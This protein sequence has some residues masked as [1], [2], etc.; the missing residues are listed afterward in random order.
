MTFVSTN[1]DHTYVYVLESCKP[2]HAKPAFHWGAN[3][4]YRMN[5]SGAAEKA[6]ELSTAAKIRAPVLRAHLIRALPLATPPCGPGAAAVHGVCHTTAVDLL[7]ATVSLRSGFRGTGVRSPG[8]CP[9][10]RSFL[11]WILSRWSTVTGTEEH[12]SGVARMLALYLPVL[13]FRGRGW[14]RRAWSRGGG[15]QAPSESQDCLW[16]TVLLLWP[17]GLTPSRVLMC[18]RTC[19]T[20]TG[21]PSGD[22]RHLS[23][24]KELSVQLRWAF[25]GR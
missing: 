4:N 19:N 6:Q 12:M 5:R 16:A 14:G 8:A 9:S 11:S 21:G 22:Q 2:K 23:N 1:L 24:Y 7:L 17:P 18:R 25:E 13:Q 10:D 20:R 3:E 15:D